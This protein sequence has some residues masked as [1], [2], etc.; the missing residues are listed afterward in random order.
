MLCA[1]D[2]G[3]SPGVNRAIRDL[4]D[5]RPHQCDLGDGG[6]RRLRPR[7]D[8]R[9]SPSAAAEGNGADRTASDADRAVP[10]AD[11]AFPPAARQR[12]P[13]ADA[14]LRAGFADGSTA[15][16]CAPR[17]RRR[18]RPSPPPSA[19]PPDFVD[20]HQ[21]VHLYPTVRD[22]LVRGRRRPRRRTPGSGNAAARCRC[23]SGSTARRRCFSTGSEPVSSAAPARPASRSIRLLPAPMTSTGPPTSPRCLRAS[24]TACRTAA[25]SCAIRALS[26]TS[27]G[28]STAS[29]PLREREYA[30]FAGD[31]LPRRL[32]AENVTLL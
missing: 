17:S 27:C 6:R 9:R 18:S 13:A 11:A 25:S 20:G 22:A 7:R 14:M 12:L 2:Y 5:K 29:P 30:Y 32:L 3:I 24:S 31:E 4:I 23:R 15:T 26:T 16:S 19:A 8:A 10:A 21:H 1:D 28:G